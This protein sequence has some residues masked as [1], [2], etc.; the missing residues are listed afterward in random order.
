M[1]LVKKIE[2][3]S[4]RKQAFLH[5]ENISLRKTQNFHFSKGVKVSFFIVAFYQK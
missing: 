1:L 4:Y 3:F 5:Y 2:I